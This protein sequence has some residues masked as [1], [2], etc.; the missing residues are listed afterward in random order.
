MPLI[1]NGA[2]VEDGWTRIEGE[3]P[4]PDGGDVLIDWSRLKE[5]ASLRVFDGR[6]GVHLPN[7]VDAN[8]LAPFVN[9]LA[10]VAFEFPSFTDGR[11]F[12]QARVL[13]HQLGFP[14]E[15]RATGNPKAD[16]GAYLIRCGIDTFEIRGMQPL[17]TWRAAI[18][19]VTRVYQRTYAEG[20]GTT[21]S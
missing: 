16:Q 21:R 19:S 17:E 4:L 20:A 5:D 6:L 18:G 10:L 3:A 14:G 2:Y 9:R 12:S 15:I 8:E 1:R 7:T 13:R 11:A